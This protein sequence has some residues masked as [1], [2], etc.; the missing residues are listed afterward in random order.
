MR[1]QK[2]SLLLPL[3]G[4]LASV[5]LQC[6]R[7]DWDWDWRED[8]ENNN[9]IQPPEEVMNIV[10]VK[11][12]MVIGQFGAGRGRYTLHL[13]Q[14]VGATGCIYANDID[15]SSLEFLRERCEQAGLKNV[16]TI[17]GTYDDPLFP[18]G[19]LD[20][21]FSTLV[22]HEIGNPV[23]F[24]KNLIPA[25]K[26]GAPIVIID[27]NPKKNTEESNVGRDWKKEFADAGLEIVK[28]EPLHERD[29][30]VILKKQKG[31]RKIHSTY[32]GRGQ[33]DQKA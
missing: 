33:H 14:R 18:R 22:Y 26:P 29:V 10:G 13:A 8:E 20:M 5:S 24:L 30:I 9:A 32:K 11:E 25:L 4:L 3:I 19:S 16:Q 7:L 23:V 27:Y 28:M 31:N 2:R 12:G 21:A 15:E 1:K 6:S 17:I